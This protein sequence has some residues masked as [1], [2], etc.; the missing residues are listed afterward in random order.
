[1]TDTPR[2][3]LTLTRQQLYDRVWSVSAVQLAKE[4]GVSDVAVAKACKRHQIPKPP[5]GYWAK[6]A[7]GK[8][9][10]RPALP[11]LVDPKL[12][13]V[14][15]SP[16]PPRVARTPAPGDVEA[17]A[18]E[19]PASRS[20]EILDLLSRVAQSDLSWEVPAS[21]RKPHPS[22]ASTLE[23]LRRCQKENRYV[24]PGEADL[25][26]PSSAR[27]DVALLD[28]R[29]SKAMMERAA[30]LA[31]GILD[32]ALAVGFELGQ[33]RE[34]YRSHFFLELFHHRIQFGIRELSTR[35]PHVPTAKELADQAKYSFSKPPKWDYHPNG[36]LRVVLYAHEWRHGFAEFADGKVRPVEQMVREIVM[37]MLGE[38][39][40]HLVRQREER[41]RQRR[42]FAEAEA[43]RR[44]EEQRKAEQQ[45]V[46][47]LVAQVER[48]ELANRIR[49]YRRAVLRAAIEQGTPLEADGPVASWLRWVDEIA[50][51]FDPLVRPR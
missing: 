36:M 11:V 37:A 48:W 1:M 26:Y 16:A 23:G 43:P 30:R 2:P 44:E 25:L 24:R 39:D 35:E 51:R 47:D 6:L 49:R 14:T 13:S 18:T 12:Q 40:R 31:Q 10:P 8:A 32:A 21:L 42:A 46:D 5:L 50:D 41:E 29:V 45:R 38:V 9:P 3:P 4:L 7:A 27:S 15:F 19:G 34:Q 17:P 28:V 22:V 33:H 20:P